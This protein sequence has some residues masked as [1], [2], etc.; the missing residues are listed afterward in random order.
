MKTD[1]FQLSAPGSASITPH[2]R[3]ISAAWRMSCLPALSAGVGYVLCRLSVAGWVAYGHVNGLVFMDAAMRPGDA[4]VPARKSDPVRVLHRDDAT[5]LF[6]W[7]EVE[8]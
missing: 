5:G 6:S 4:A 7:A 1:S 2:L 8:S 3:E